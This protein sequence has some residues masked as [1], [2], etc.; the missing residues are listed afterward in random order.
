MAT[1]EWLWSPD[2][3]SIA[4]VLLTTSLALTRNSV[5][6]VG[7]EPGLQVNCS[8]MT[9]DWVAAAPASP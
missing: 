4:A 2:V 3:L 6:P 9:T 7:E 1:D 5:P 8:A